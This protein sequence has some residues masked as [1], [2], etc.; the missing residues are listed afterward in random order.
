MPRGARRPSS[1]GERLVAIYLDQRGLCWEHEPEIGGRHLDFVVECAVG[2]V[3]L[4][5]Y[6]PHLRLP[7]RF[8]SYDSIGPVEGAFSDRK[9]KQ[10]KAA[11]QA[12]LPLVLVIGSANSDVPYDVL[13]IAGV[14]FGRPGVR[15]TV[16]P[17]G[18]ATDPTA[19]FL[20]P[21]KVQPDVNRGASALALI[22]RFNP[23]L[24]RLRAAWRSAG[25]IDRS[26]P[27]T[28]RAR[29]EVYERMR[30]IEATMTRSGV[31]LPEA[32]IARLVI[33]HNPFADNPLP[34]RFAGS[35]DDQYGALESGS[36]WGLLATGRLRREVPDD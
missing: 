6:E 27:D 36:E 1:D 16:H 29:C 34:R 28:P 15:M 32:R 10:I 8:G 21:G 7:N 33:A 11:K 22:R 4:E 13:S 35:H 5:V 20:G 19:A 18:V 23:T 30:V 17:E 24:W 25:L 14:M 31:Y 2:S 3:A 26:P 12:G 9:R